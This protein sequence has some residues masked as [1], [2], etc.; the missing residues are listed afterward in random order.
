MFA[1]RTLTATALAALISAMPAGF[2]AAQEASSA[3]DALPDSAVAGE[4]TAETT[5]APATEEGTDTFEIATLEAFA[6][7]VIDVTEIRDDYAAQLDGVSDETEQR[8]LIEEANAEMQNAIVERE[9]LTVEEYMTI[10]RA[11]AED[12]ELNAVI[13]QL[14]Q[15]MQTED[16]G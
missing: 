15:D 12:E 2:V 1:T 11:A 4:E 6:A 3:A 13:A 9:D 8:T 5:E 7:A 16:A 10:A 14:L